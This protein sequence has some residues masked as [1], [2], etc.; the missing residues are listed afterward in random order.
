MIMIAYA[1][2]NRLNEI[3]SGFADS[4][5]EAPPSNIGS[6]LDESAPRKN[7]LQTMKISDESE[8]EGGITEVE[9]GPNPEQAKYILMSLEEELYQCHSS[10]TETWSHQS[11]N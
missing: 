6:M 4:E 2:R 9:L 5:E 11:Q 8:G 7:W 10:F 3:I 1:R